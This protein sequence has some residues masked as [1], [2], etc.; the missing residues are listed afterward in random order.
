[1]TVISQIK[2]QPIHFISFF[3]HCLRFI[4]KNC[5][6]YESRFWKVF[7]IWPNCAPALQ[8]LF[9]VG[10]LA[11]LSHSGSSACNAVQLTIWKVI[12]F[13]NRK[14]N[15]SRH[16]IHLWF[17]LS[18]YNLHKNSTEGRKNLLKV[19]NWF[20]CKYIEI[21]NSTIFVLSNY[22]HEAAG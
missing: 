21:R 7:V 6:F 16:L 18:Q 20:L 19:E 12:D 4:F 15:E 1:M 8:V 17:F 9:W 22:Y 5:Q 10:V 2:F 3:D 14:R 11:R 13:S